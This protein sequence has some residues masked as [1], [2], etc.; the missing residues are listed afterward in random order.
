MADAAFS[1]SGAEGCIDIDTMLQE[2]RDTQ[3]PM[4]DARE[5]DDNDDLDDDDDE[6]WCSVPMFFRSA[7]EESEYA[8]SDRPG[9][10]LCSR[11]VDVEYLDAMEQA[12]AD[13]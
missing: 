6:E 5:A 4:F 1:C 8:Y 10:V 11:V 13:P 3:V 7:T 12:A 2:E 9:S